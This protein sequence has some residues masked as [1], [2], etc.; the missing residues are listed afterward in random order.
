MDGAEL[1][2]TLFYILALNSVQRNHSTSERELSAGVKT[3]DAFRAFLLGRH[4]TLRSDYKAL[5]VILKSAICVEESHDLVA[6]VRPIWIRHRSDCWQ[7][8]RS[9][10]FPFTISIAR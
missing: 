10:P 3:C 7:R 6:S 8:E 2:S 5:Q 1:V 4:F 9:G